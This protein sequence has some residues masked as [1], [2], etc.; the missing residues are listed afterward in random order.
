[1]TGY[2]DARLSQHKRLIGPASVSGNPI[3]IEDGRL[4]GHQHLISRA[5]FL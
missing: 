2:L 4:S 1:V 3:K 5:I